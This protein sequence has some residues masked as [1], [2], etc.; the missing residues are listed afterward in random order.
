ML[1][2]QQQLQLIVGD[3]EGTQCVELFLEA[4]KNNGAGGLCVT[5]NQRLE[6][7]AQYHKAVEQVLV[8]SDNYFK[9]IVYKEGGKIS[10]EMLETPND[11]EDESDGDN[12]EEG[13]NQSSRT[14]RSSAKNNAGDGAGGIAI[15]EAKVIAL[16]NERI[17]ASPRF[18]KRE[19][20]RFK[21]LYS[22]KKD[23]ENDTAVLK[24]EGEETQA[25]SS[26]EKDAG[27]AAAA[28]GGSK[29]KD[30]DIEE[31]QFNLKNYQRIILVHKDIFMSKDA[32]KVARQ[33]SSSA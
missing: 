24:E 19:I 21:K 17:K 9:L 28:A 30:V 27:T 33:V 15:D 2:T 7:E 29:T 1:S 5:A 13:S 26:D 22:E 23:T 3:E 12:D 14:L 20:E 32:F 16:A 31:C 10:L 11:D 6:A 4:L 25:L 8:D 18:L